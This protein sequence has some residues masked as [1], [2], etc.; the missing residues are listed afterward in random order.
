MSVN[1][2]VKFVGNV[3]LFANI[4]LSAPE[5][6]KMRKIA[7]DFGACSLKMPKLAD[8]GCGFV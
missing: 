1:G 3:I 5:F 7:L 4:C 8:L 6:C 2:N